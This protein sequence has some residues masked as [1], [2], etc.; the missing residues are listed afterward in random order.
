MSIFASI[1]RSV[2]KLSGAKKAFALPE[3][4]LRKEIEKQNRHR[5]VF[6]PTDHKAY[7]ETIAVN[8]FPAQSRAGDHAVIKTVSARHSVRTANGFFSFHGSSSVFQ[9]SHDLFRSH[10]FKM[11]TIF[12]KSSF[13]SLKIGSIQ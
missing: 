1:L 13:A 7:Y 2:Y 8:G 12:A 11:S 5:G 10:F 9:S 3:D 4:A 6:T